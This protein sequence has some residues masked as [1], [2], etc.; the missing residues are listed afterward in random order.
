[1]NWILLLVILSEI[2]ILAIAKDYYRVLG[3]RRGA[4]QDEIK[5]AYR[6]LAKQ[7]HPDKN[8][9]SG[10]EDKMHEINE[11]YEALLNKDKSTNGFDWLFGGQTGNDDSFEAQ[12]PKGASI[13]LSLPVTLEEVYSG[14]TIEVN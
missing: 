8:S 7:Y 6:K 14:K 1:M 4:S 10:A 12:H 11:A 5:K 9:D 3:L 2:V 13:H